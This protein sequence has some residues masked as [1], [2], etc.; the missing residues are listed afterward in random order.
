MLGAY[1]IVTQRLRATAFNFLLLLDIYPKELK[2]LHMDVPLFI[3]DHKYESNQ[4]IHGGAC[5][6]YYEVKQTSV[7]MPM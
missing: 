6:A 3:I 1:R 4:D 5:T 7:R 2:N